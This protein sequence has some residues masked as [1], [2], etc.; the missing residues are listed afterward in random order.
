MLTSRPQRYINTTKPDCQVFAVNC[1]LLHTCY[2][3]RGQVRPWNSPLPFRLP[4]NCF[5]QV[6]CALKCK[7]PAKCPSVALSGSESKWPDVCSDQQNH[8]C[9]VKVLMFSWYRVSLMQRGLLL[10]LCWNES[11]EN[12]KPYRG[13]AWP[14]RKICDNRKM[15]LK[16]NRTCHEDSVRRAVPH[17]HCSGSVSLIRNWIEGRRGLTYKSPGHEV[18]VYP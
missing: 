13:T 10:W 8:I 17:I 15:P 7:K 14:D 2:P 1:L 5:E 18:L 11:I 6:R 4:V 9:R 3:N 12:T 16:E